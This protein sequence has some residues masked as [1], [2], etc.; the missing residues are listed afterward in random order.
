M[1]GLGFI[2]MVKDSEEVSVVFVPLV[3]SPMGEVFHRGCFRCVAPHALT[4]SP[5]LPPVLVQEAIPGPRP[6]LCVIQRGPGGYGFNLHSERARP[7]QYIRAVD[8]DSPA[9]SAG[10][11]PKDRIVEVGAVIMGCTSTDPMN[12]TN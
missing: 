5:S 4:R 3:L 1:F 6:R 12:Y 2:S 10:L 11:L 7:G 8:V 9:E